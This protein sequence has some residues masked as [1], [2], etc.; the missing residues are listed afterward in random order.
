MTWF[1]FGYTARKNVRLLFN[2]DV[3]R[4]FSIIFHRYPESHTPIFSPHLSRSNDARIPARISL[5]KLLTLSTDSVTKFLVA[6]TTV[7]FFV[8]ESVLKVIS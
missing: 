1:L 8:T 6:K 2:N 3:S 5:T 7:I 4:D